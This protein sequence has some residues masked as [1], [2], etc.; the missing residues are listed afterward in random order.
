MPKTVWNGAPVPWFLKV[1]LL[2]EI[3][4]GEYPR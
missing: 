1:N 2:S 3:V 4:E